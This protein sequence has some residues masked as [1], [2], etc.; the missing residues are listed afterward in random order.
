MSTLKKTPGKLELVQNESEGTTKVRSV[1]YSEETSQY[2]W[3]TGDH[4][5]MEGLVGLMNGKKSLNHKAELLK[6]AFQLKRSLTPELFQILDECKQRL[7]LDIDVEIYSYQDTR[8]N[9]FISF[10]PEK[11]GPITMALSSGLIENFTYK[12]IQFVIGHELGHYIFN[13]LSLPVSY[14]LQN[15]NDFTSP[16]HAM[17]LSAWQRNSEISADR[18]GLICN[19]DLDS[20]ITAF[21]KLS[22]GITSNVNLE[23]NDYIQQFKDLEDELKNSEI[24]PNE[25]YSTHPCGA[26]RVRAIELFSKSNLYHDLIE[27]TENGNCFNEIENEIS[28]FMNLLEPDYLKDQSDKGKILQQLLFYCGYYIA[29]ADAQLDQ[30]E[31][32]VLQSLISIEVWNENLQ[33]IE[34]IRSAVEMEEKLKELGTAAHIHLS[35]ADRH[36]IIRDLAIIVYADGEVTRE[37]MDALYYIC[38]GLG[39]DPNF[40]HSIVQQIVNQS[41]QAA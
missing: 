32:E 11:Q 28:R 38:H 12:E 37:E 16:L 41:Q 2:Q 5:F 34:K 15:G 35:G 1:R 8:F 27:K 33:D 29:M 24:N 17:K 31:I 3:L 4:V 10:D 21:F 14:I 20:V 6:T 7:H 26:I 30:S 25:F 23:V 36:N 9:A 40:A 13:H 39:V 22:S 19:Q 18:I